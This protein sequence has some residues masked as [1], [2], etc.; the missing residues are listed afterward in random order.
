MHTNALSKEFGYGLY[1]GLTGLVVQPAKGAKEEGLVG[2]GK[3]V[4]KGSL[5]VAFK[6]ASGKFFLSL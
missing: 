4:F 6:P 2:F 1:D 5:G 3:G